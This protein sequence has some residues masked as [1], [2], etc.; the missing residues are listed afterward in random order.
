MREIKFRAWDRKAKALFPIHK[1]E[2]HKISNELMHLSGVDIHHADSDWEGDICYGGHPAKMTGHP[3]QPRYELMQYT[4]L[5][6]RNGKEIY[7]GDI[8][9]SQKLGFSE[10]GHITGMVEII[11]TVKFESGRFILRNL[12]TGA[13]PDLAFGINYHEVV[14]NMYKN[15]ELLEAP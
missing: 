9:K 4:G 14:G 8:I 7:E 10:N 12:E 5:K 2:W 3:L 6:D 11:G 15:S 13:M 1:L